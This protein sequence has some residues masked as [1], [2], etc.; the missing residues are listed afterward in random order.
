MQHL[1]EN[2]LLELAILL[3]LALVYIVLRWIVFRRSITHKEFENISLAV[4]VISIL[5]LFIIT[6]WR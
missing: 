4:I 5:A 3:G 6:I 1:K 2:F